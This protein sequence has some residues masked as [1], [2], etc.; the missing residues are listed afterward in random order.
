MLRPLFLACIL[1]SYLYGSAQSEAV[2]LKSV[3]SLISLKK[4]EASIQVCSKILKQNPKSENALINRGYAY[5]NLNK[6]AAA[7]KD[8]KDAIKFN[9]KCTT[10]FIQAGIIKIFQ[11]DKVA[12][13]F[14]AEQALKLDS[15]S[16]GA[17]TV[18]GRISKS[19]DNYKE[20][21]GYFNK[22]VALNNSNT[23]ALYHRAMNYFGLNQPDRAMNDLITINKIMPEFA[24]AYYEKGIWL[25]NQQKL[26]IV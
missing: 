11:G 16:S 20:A 12:A 15:N 18:K 26:I 14:F 7:E 5:L 24:L 1:L 8:Y 3:D 19:N 22:A 4:W 25:A 23:E 9:S 13:L 2:L 6:L 10:C 21:E 17:Y